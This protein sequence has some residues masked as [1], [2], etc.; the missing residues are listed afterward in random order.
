MSSKVCLFVWVLRLFVTVMDISRPC[1]P[2]KLI[3]LLPWPGFDPSFSRHNDR[4]AINSEWTWLRL[5]SLSHRAGNVIQGKILS[6]KLTGHMWL[7]ICIHIQTL[8]IRCTVSEILAEIDHKCQNLTF[9]T[10]KMTFRVI[11]YLSYFRTGLVSQQR[12]YMMQYI[13]AALHYYWIIS[14]IM[15]KWAKPDLSELENDLNN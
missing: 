1:Q 7:T 15:G 3:P 13:W 11:P 10:L 8:I 5:R 12:S 9:L 14:I 4:R 6:G 2:E